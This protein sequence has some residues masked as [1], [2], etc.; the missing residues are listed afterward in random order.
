MTQVENKVEIQDSYAGI[1]KSVSQWVVVNIYYGNLG[2]IPVTESPTTDVVGLLSNIG[3]V[4][5]WLNDLK[6][7]GH[8]SDIQCYSRKCIINNGNLEL[9]SEASCL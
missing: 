4:A 2:F 6:I 3:R 7:Y 9:K 5:I 8:Q 1:T